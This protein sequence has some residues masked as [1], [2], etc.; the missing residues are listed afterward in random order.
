MP[1]KYGL[2]IS[3]GFTKNQ[4]EEASKFIYCAFPGIPGKDGK[5]AE[6]VT[7]SSPATV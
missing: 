5:E 2:W 6:D 3:K 7:P 1:I 4:H